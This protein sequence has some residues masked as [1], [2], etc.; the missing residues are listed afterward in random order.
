MKRYLKS[1]HTR[2]MLTFMTIMIVT[3][4]ILG[5]II[6]NII[7]SF[8]LDT[9]LKELYETNVQVSSY[10][11]V[12]PVDGELP[13]IENERDGKLD[14]FLEETLDTIFLVSPQAGILVF[15]DKGELILFASKQDDDFV[16]SSE[17][18]EE[19][20]G[21]I[22]EK[23]TLPASFLNQIA[24][25]KVVSTSDTADGYFENI[26]YLY[27]TAITTSVIKV[28]PPSEE[29][30]EVADSSI[31]SEVDTSTST[32]TDAELPEPVYEEKLLG[33]IIC[34]DLGNTENDKMMRDM[35]IA[36]FS[37][38][39]WIT[40]ASLV[41]IYGVS[42]YTMKPLREI[43]HAAKSFSRG[44]FDVRVKVRGNDELASLADSFNKMAIAIQ[45]K[46]EM[47]KNFLSNVSHDL[48]T[49]MT[50]IA[51][52]IDGILDGAIPPEKEEYYLNIIKNE[53]KRLSRL[54]T[55]LLD[56]SRLQ[57]GERKFEFKQFN[58]S[59][60]VRQT[61]LS[62]EKPIGEKKLDVDFDMDDFDMMAYGDK[63]AINQVVYNLCHNAIKFS[64]EGAKYK[65]S[66]KYYGTDTIKFTMF[67][68]GVGISSEDLPFVFDRFYKSDKSRGLDKTGTGL[69]LFIAK[70]IVDAHSQSIEARSEY[71]KWCE[72]SFT[73]ARTDKSAQRGEQK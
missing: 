22:T 71:G 17:Y 53:I 59:E 41:A 60:L 38:I 57:S 44:K 20:M 26:V 9:K 63:D 42:Y 65:V 45:S 50:T 28:E 7:S 54:V 18:D 39:L 33:A 21:G 29:N 15:D 55:S 25:N 62:L 58:L 8:S 47:Q 32:E 66:L 31:E 3:I 46:D 69:G 10:F 34:Y 1:I 61:V 68:E 43:G 56:I 67:N 73:I 11:K 35:M 27:A 51:G 64:S 52:F 13:P 40:L 49:P 14:P 19:K 72:M 36:I 2:Y 23:Q 5:I 24:R 70:T 30:D 16:S 4:L 12:R 37:T 48:K 6:T